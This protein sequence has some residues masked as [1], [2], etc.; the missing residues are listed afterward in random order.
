M[1]DRLCELNV[2]A[3][4]ENVCRTEI[5]RRAWERGQ[6]LCVHGW[7]YRLAR[8]AAA[9]SRRDEAQLVASVSAR[10]Q[11]ALFGVELVARD[12]AL[13]ADLAV[14]ER[15]ARPGRRRPTRGTSRGRTT[16]STG[17]CQAVPRSSR[18][19]S[20]RSTWRCRRSSPRMLRS[21]ASVPMAWS[22]NMKSFMNRT[23]S[24]GSRSPCAT[25]ALVTLRI[26]RSI[27]SAS[28]VAGS[29]SGRS[30]GIVLEELLEIG[31]RWGARRAPGSPGAP[32]R[33][34]P[35]I[36]ESIILRKVPRRSSS[37]RPV[38]P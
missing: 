6:Q 36:D 7:I 9:R 31:V 22:T 37:M 8:R 32:R 5:V 18:R 35:A 15:L 17:R 3:Q 23:I 13:L 29:T 26:S 21:G 10:R 1:A 2:A 12:L 25:S 24:L 38:M 27:S 34:S 33:W 11:S 30:T 4:V 28:A 16:P 20:S 19:G 14:G